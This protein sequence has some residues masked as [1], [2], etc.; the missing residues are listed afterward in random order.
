MG[1]PTGARAGSRRAPYARLAHRGALSGVALLFDPCGLADAVTQVEELGAPDGTPADD[2][3]ALDDG[4]VHRKG[5]LDPDAVAELADG[6]RL[7]D[8]GALATDDDA[9][10]ELHT[11]LVALD[12]AHVDLQ[13]VARSE[14]RDVIPE[15]RLVDEVGAVHGAVLNS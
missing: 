10:E 8:A 3:D 12:H 11:L 9:L 1:P 14:V 7:A 2:L 13:G 5:A 6:E 15:A 4:R